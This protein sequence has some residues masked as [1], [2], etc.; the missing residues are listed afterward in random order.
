MISLI[1]I[2]KL[3]TQTFALEQLPF[4]AS[5]CPEVGIQEHLMTA[6]CALPKSNSIGFDIVTAAT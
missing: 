2:H 5:L 1:T 4:Y 6:H 3:L